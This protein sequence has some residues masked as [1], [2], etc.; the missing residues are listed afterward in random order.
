MHNFCLVFHCELIERF[1]LCY[2][3]EMNKNMIDGKKANDCGCNNLFIYFEILLNQIKPTVLGH[4][5][6]HK[7]ER[8]SGEKLHSCQ[9]LLH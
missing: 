9:S 2:H 7:I 6:K 3:Q 8:Y 4:Q 1:T 5:S